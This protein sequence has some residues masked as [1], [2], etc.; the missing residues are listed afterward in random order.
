MNDL[1]EVL[2]ELEK[3]KSRDAM[4]YE[5]SSSRNLHFIMKYFTNPV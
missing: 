4:G 1:E 5:R 3:D 2:K